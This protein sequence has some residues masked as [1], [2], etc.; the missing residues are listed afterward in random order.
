MS[1]LQDIQNECTEKDASVSRLLRLCLRLAAGLK[2]DALKNWVIHELNGY[3]EDSLLPEYRVFPVSS[4][5]YFIGSFGRSATL[6]ISVSVLPKEAQENYRYA[7]LNQPIATYE[8]LI[9]GMDSST[10]QLELAWPILLAVKYGS[11]MTPD[12]QCVKAWQQL[13]PGAVFGL[14]D[15]IKTRVLMMAIE[16]E[17]NDPNAGDVLS[18]PSNIKESVVN[19]IINN[20]IIGSQIQNV[21]VGLGGITQSAS[22]QVN[23][24]DLTSLTTFLERIGI[25]KDDVAALSQAVADDKAEGAPGIGKRALGW[26]A[27][28]GKAAAE[29]GG[30]EAGEILV[31]QVKDAITAYLT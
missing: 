10:G 21:A 25:P 5:G 3:P 12:M 22:E 23:S 29:A 9:Q 28:F 6:Q 20:T 31:G 8:S 2:N 13:A 4:S 30:K 18:I 26:L 14:V 1:L 17:T 16:I 7:R 15:T 11:K 24:G 19:Q 27:K